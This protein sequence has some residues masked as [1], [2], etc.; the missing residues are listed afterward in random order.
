MFFV[1]LRIANDGQVRYNFQPHPKQV[2]DIMRIVSTNKHIPDDVLCRSFDQQ[3]AQ[4]RNMQVSKLI[5]APLR[6]LV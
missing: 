1:Q 6:G 2:L 5:G 4:G 3:T